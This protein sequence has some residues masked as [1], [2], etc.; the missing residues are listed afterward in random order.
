[1][2]HPK[3]NEF[4]FNW[5]LV[6]DLWKVM[7]PYFVSSGPRQPWYMTWFLAIVGGFT[8]PVLSTIYAFMT[9]KVMGPEGTP[10]GVPLDAL[11]PSALA[12]VVGT[13]V[14][15][16]L[17][18]GYTLGPVR[19]LWKTYTFVGIVGVAVAAVVPFIAGPN[20][21]EPFTIFGVMAQYLAG[22]LPDLSGAADHKMLIAILGV[23]L[24]LAAPTYF[25]W[26]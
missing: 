6:K 3:E 14:S 20:P 2:N 15:V 19:K 5:K 12:W 9:Q 1:M 18:Y 26:G 16:A 4:R 13:A 22:M 10:V 7:T 24:A 8:V 11:M 23:P 17:I 21:D 25:M